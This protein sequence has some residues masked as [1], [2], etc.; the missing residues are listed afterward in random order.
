[1][2]NMRQIQ[3][4]A[5]SSITNAAATSTN[6]A[7]AVPRRGIK[8]R[9]PRRSETVSSTVMTPP[10]Q[11]HIQTPTL[12]PASPAASASTKPAEPTRTLP[13]PVQTVS[14]QPVISSINTRSPNVS[15]SN[16]II[17]IFNFISFQQR[18]SL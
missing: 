13:M 17:E 15:I 16:K 14:A 11:S 18:I 4:N 9:S 7:S 2:Q 3:Q 10:V 1:M 8:V 6:E 12:H 5:K